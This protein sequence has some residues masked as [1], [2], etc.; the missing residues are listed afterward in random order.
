MGVCLKRHS[1]SG[2]HAAVLNS[3]FAALVFVKCRRSARFCGITPVG[4]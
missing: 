3:H 4:T 2:L 1:R